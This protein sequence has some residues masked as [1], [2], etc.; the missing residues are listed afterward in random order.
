MNTQIQSKQAK[1]LV[2]VDGS[3]RSLETVRYISRM[4]PF[5]AM[6][7]VLLHIFS[8][9]PDCYW[10][11]AREPKSIKITPEIKAW[12]AGQKKLIENS[13][14]E[15]R[16]ILI[17]AGFSRNNIITKIKN[18]KKGI[19]RD[20]IR[21]AQNGYLAVVLRRRGMGALKRMVLGSVAIKLI[22]KLSF[23]P[24][25]IVGWQ[26]VGRKILIPLD[27][28]KCAWR[29]VAFAADTLGGH[30][31]QARFIYVIRDSGLDKAADR[32]DVFAELCPDMLRQ[33]IQGVFDKAERQLI[34]AGF[35]ADAVSSKMMFGAKSR[36]EAIAKEASDNEYDTIVMGRR[37]LSGVKDF[38]I[39][40]VS[41]KVIHIA[42][43]HH[44]WVVPE[45]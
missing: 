42:R 35:Q 7:I 3:E 19:A 38:F 8:G 12:E 10:D 24:V 32:N 1:I 23:I 9:V 13:M 21:E 26:P 18:R 34:E 11:L 36:A 33:E 22:E 5:G 40:R 14:Q 39:G 27:G 25:M 15:A 45:K 31:Y 28:S 6:K 43:K 37:G 16:Q 30:A 4:E 44:I 2:A 29:A 20:I 41:N 17:Q